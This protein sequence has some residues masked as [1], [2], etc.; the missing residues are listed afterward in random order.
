MRCT[1]MVWAVVPEIEHQQAATMP[2]LPLNIHSIS[3]IYI[4][5]LLLFAKARVND[6]TQKERSLTWFFCNTV[7]VRGHTCNS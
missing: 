3:N 4:Y 2:H 6:G 5:V 1:P 7:C